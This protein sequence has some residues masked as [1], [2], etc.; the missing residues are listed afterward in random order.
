VTFT[1]VDAVLNK[2]TQINQ[3]L[4][5]LESKADL[6]FYS[7]VDIRD[8]GFKMAFIDTNLFPAGF[9]NLCQLALSD[10]STTFK[11]AI[12]HRVANAK[13]LL[14]IIEEHTRNT[15]YLENVYVLEQ[16]MKS[17]GFEV[18]IASFLTPDLILNPD[19]T[20]YIT[21]DTAKNNPINLYCLHTLLEDVKTKKT[22]FDL[23]ILNHDL[24]T[25]IPDILAQTQ[26]PI[27][28]SIQAG[29]HS[30]LKSNHFSVANTLLDE[31]ASMI[32]IDSWFFSCLYTAVESVDINDPSDRERLKHSATRLFDQIQ[33]KYDTH[34]INKKPFVFLKADSGTY[35]MGVIP[36]ESP[37]DILKF[38]R[39]ARNNLTK[40]KNS[41]KIGRFILQE[42]VPSIGTVD[43]LVSE[44]CIYQVA[45]QFV[46]GFYRLNNQKNDRE[47][48]NSKGMI[49]RKMCVGDRGECLYSHKDINECGVNPDPKTQVYHILARIA[50][51][52]AHREIIQMIENK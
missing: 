6:P 20:P 19:I 35:G 23:I 51:V 40:G 25:G 12:F 48:L 18:I 31:F 41:R 27:Y 2:Q 21:L 28:P 52:A 45:N 33:Q 29:W 7:S 5:Q 14:M 3:W 47:N 8:A 39:K 15:W 43:G 24:T 44:V 30:R 46:G 17:A 34:H 32:G 10:A 4:T 16:L 26:I 1:I 50:G 37:E 11:K 22:A 9:N 49:F 42:G 38:N 13:R 36:I